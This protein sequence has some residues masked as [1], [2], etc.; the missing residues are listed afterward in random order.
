[1][2]FKRRITRLGAQ[3][4]LLR[5]DAGN[6]H[7]DCAK[8]VGNAAVTTA[9]FEHFRPPLVAHES[10]RRDISSEVQA[11][12]NHGRRSALH[13]P[14]GTLKSQLDPYHPL[15]SNFRA[16]TTTAGLPRATARAECH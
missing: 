15:P 3:F 12:N 8:G 11:I 16:F 5:I 7:P 4:L 1:M 2:E 10:R 14:S 13:R 6:A 9:Q